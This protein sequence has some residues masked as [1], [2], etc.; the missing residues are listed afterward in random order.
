MTTLGADPNTYED[1]KV[2][3]RVNMRAGSIGTSVPVIA[4]EQS[5][6]VAEEV[7]E[8]L[9]QDAQADLD[10][11]A[12]QGLED[13]QS[14]LSYQYFLGGEGVAPDFT[15]AAYWEDKSKEKRKK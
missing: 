3:K 1:K 5:V 15:K 11:A 10:R 12:N 13:A 9:A 4:V 8:G 7:E 6:K 2:N 14:M